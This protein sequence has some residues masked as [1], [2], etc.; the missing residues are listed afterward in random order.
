MTSLQAPEE[1][2]DEKIEGNGIIEFH[3]FVDL[4][5]RRPWGVQGSADELRSAFRVFDRDSTGQ[6]SLAELRRTMK[7]IGEP[8]SDEDLDKMFSNLAID[9][10]W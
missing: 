3:E 1:L 9:G 4:M 7:T 8:V 6:L 5:S 10:D 2:S